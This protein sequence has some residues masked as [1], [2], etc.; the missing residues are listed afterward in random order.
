MN[1]HYSR[2]MPSGKLV[3]FGVWEDKRFI[4]AVIYGRGT[5]GHLVK[6][7]GLDPTQG[8]E[9]V[10]IA[11]TRHEAPVSKVV[12]IT[13]KILKAQFPK[14]RLIVSFAAESQGHYGGVYQAGNWVYTGATSLKKEFL[15]KGKRASDRTIYGLAS[16]VPGG[17]AELERRGIISL[18]D[19]MKKHRYLMP[20][21][22]AMRKQIELLA[23]PYPKRAPSETSDTVAFQVA[24]G[25]ATPT[26]A[27]HSSLPE[28]SNDSPESPVEHKTT[29][30]WSQRNV[31]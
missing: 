4:G 17:R 3:K 29:L 18:L 14:L 8:C 2:A 1:W 22:K 5:C 25:G 20:L 9:L 6:G 7:Y 30:K 27:L 13:N 11:L 15:Y 23:K 19:N 21:D 12:A 10:R 16:K 31:R 28:D 26:G 24:K